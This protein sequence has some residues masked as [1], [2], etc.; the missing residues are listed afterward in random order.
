MLTI[1]C[2]FP[3]F[4]VFVHGNDVHQQPGHRLCLPDD[5]VEISCSHN[6]KNY[7]TILWYQKKEGDTAM[8]LIGYI[9]YTTIKS[10]EAP[11]TN[12]FNVSGDGEKNASLHFSSINTAL[13]AVYF[14]AAY[15]AQH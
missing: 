15:Y 11:W 9:S 6:I 7:D 3:W 4:T 10:I 13:S 8:K 1:I 5:K 14:C 12:V 2:L